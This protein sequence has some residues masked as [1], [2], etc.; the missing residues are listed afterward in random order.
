L[1]LALLACNPNTSRPAFGP[2]PAAIEAEL[3][4]PVAVAVQVVTEALRADSIPVELIRERD[5]YLET[6][7]FQARDG[8]PTTARPLGAEIVRVRVWAT[9]GRVG[10]TDLELEVVYRPLA[11]PSRPPRELDRLVAAEH[12][13]H[14]RLEAAVTRLVTQFGHPDQLPA[15]PDTAARPDTTARPDTIPVPRGASRTGSLSSTP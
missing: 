5:G 10:H 9:P 14:R 4:L 6:P 12:P 1:A 15:R 11:D 8:A 13:V 2:L 7:W 3:E